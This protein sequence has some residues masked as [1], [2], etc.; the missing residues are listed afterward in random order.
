MSRG[1][2]ANTLSNS[3][4]WEQ[5]FNQSQGFYLQYIVHQLG[6]KNRKLSNDDASEFLE[7]I[8]LEKAPLFK[9]K[10]ISKVKSEE[11][12]LHSETLFHLPE[13][14]VWCKLEEIGEAVIGL[15]YKPSEISEN[16]TPVLRA[17]NIKDNKIQYNDVV[18]VTAKVRD[19]QI[20]N[21]G[22][23]L[24]CVRSGS[25]NLIGK[26]AIIDRDGFSFGAFMSL[27][28]SPI[29]DYVQLF[30]TSTLCKDQINDKKSTGINQL[31]QATLRNLLIPL[32]P[33]S[34]QKMILNFL[35]D[36]EKNEL[37]QNKEYFDSEIESKVLSIHK[38]QLHHNQIT[39]EL[40]HQLEL[41]R[42][43]RQTFL[44]EAM[45]GKLVEQD[46]TDEPTQILL[47]RIK[48]EKEKLVA[49]KKI[50]KDKPLPEIKAE[51]IPFEIPGNWI[52]CRL[53]E[54][55]NEIKYGTSKSCDYNTERNSAVL[56]IPNV[57]SG[58]IDASDLKYTDLTDEEI[59]DLSL[60]ENDILIIRSNG[61]KSLV[62][63]TALVTSEFVGYAFAG[64]LIRLRFSK[65]LINANYLMSATN[66]EYFRDLIEVPLR[67]TVGINNINTTEISNLII[68][69]PPLAEQ[70]RIVEKLEKLMAFCD[71]LEANIRES[72]TQAET[73]LQVALKEALEPK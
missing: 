31:T 4:T 6:R 9:E 63:E 51:E 35:Q 24:I 49:E 40:S 59:K 47:K 15:T 11:V 66:S 14:W 34:E 44:R 32:P 29:N 10:Q 22:D 48:A 50:K 39:T 1:R 72:K 20:A 56:R 27:F 8:S 23:I 69:L 64:Y 70:K 45:Q 55:F 36:L 60:E 57:S 61:S 21:V 7:S 67:T 68:P 58:I 5:I 73:L 12:R 28:R 17:N 13:N 65:E 33:R 62:G 41:V 26:S 2:K 16:G 43:L 53:G 25:A 18:K 54:I 37:D 52:W 30:M 3:S 71:K 19:K 42:Q 46:Y 38:G